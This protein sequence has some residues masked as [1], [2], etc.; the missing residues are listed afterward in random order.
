[1]NLN[2]LIDSLAV[3]Q[4]T[5]N[6]DLEITGMEVDSRR[7]RPGDLFIALKGF[8]VDGH[9]FIRQA[10]EKGA[11]AVVLEEEMEVEVPSIRVPDTRRA[12]AVLADVFYGHPTHD[13]NL[14]AVT[15]TNGKTT[16]THLIRNILRECGH[17]TGLIGTINMQIGDETYPVKNTTPDAVELQRGFRKMVDRGCT[18]AVI[19]ASS[20]ALHLGRT[21]GCRFKTA[22]FTN[23]TQD[24]LDYHGTMD[25]YR[26]AKGILFGQLGN[27]Y[28]DRAEDQPLAV[29]N[30]DDEAGEI[31]ME[32]TSAQVIT[33]G[34]EHPADVRGENIRFYSGGTRFTLNTY[35]G[36]VD[37]DMKLMGKFSVY[38][39]LAAAAVALGEG[40]SLEKIGEV[41]SRVKGVPGRLEAVDAG[42]PFPVLVDYAHTPDSLENV[43]TT[44]RGFTKGNIICVVGC[45]GDRDR[46]KRPQMARI[47]AENSN[48]V[49][50]TSDN[51]RTEDPRRIIDD[52]LA[53]VKDFPQDRIQVIPDRAEAIGYA[54][55]HA[56]ADDV[57]LIAGKG[58][59]TYQE[60]N[61]VRHD[62]DDRKVAR[63]AIL[64]KE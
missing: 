10:V 57:V 31:Y 32:T 61:G 55:R 63:T 39:A 9:R 42:Q 29:L 47:A 6:T 16:V 60:N 50:I 12:M 20:H 28:T 54:V 18:H 26:A 4:I 56:Q 27:V 21:R 53:G 19:E 14:I 36:S 35:R 1:M 15:G 46:G 37:I 44:V 59:E 7:V 52:M 51:P 2:T 45:G 30:I 58:H 3:A 17:E 11:R 22:V 38:N 13:L 25:H 24:H 43:L 5:G 41:L 49:V 34:V 33:Y 64:G 62:F 8:T 48:R 23:L 40:I